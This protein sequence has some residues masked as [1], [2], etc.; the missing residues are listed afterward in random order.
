[1]LVLG[2]CQGCEGSQGVIDGVVIVGKWR[3]R[4]VSY[5]VVFRSIPLA[6]SVPPCLTILVI[7]SVFAL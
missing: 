6:A 7:V 3:K 2:G 1:M 4:V 5:P